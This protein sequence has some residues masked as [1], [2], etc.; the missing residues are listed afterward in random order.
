MAGSLS[1]T[2]IAG[3]SLS[4][5]MTRRAKPSLCLCRRNAKGRHPGGATERTAF[6]DTPQEVGARQSTAHIHLDRRPQRW[7]CDEPADRFAKVEAE[8]TGRD[9]ATIARAPHH[10]AR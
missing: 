2:D 10:A 4:P 7:Q 6:R 1:G 8:A 9:G 3:P 5:D